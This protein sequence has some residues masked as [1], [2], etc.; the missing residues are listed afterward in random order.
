MKYRVNREEAIKTDS[1]VSSMRDNFY[2]VIDW[3]IFLSVYIVAFVSV[4]AIIH[5]FFPSIDINSTFPLA[6]LGVILG[7][8][9]IGAFGG[10]AA[11][12]FPETQAQM[13][14]QQ[15]YNQIAPRVVNNTTPAP[16]TG[17]TGVV[18]NDKTGKQEEV[19]AVSE[20]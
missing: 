9:F 4:A 2:R 15:Q 14:Q 7:P 19:V 6:P 16:A 12:S 20:E 17:T 1:N 5:G 10:K 3:A 13:Y 11:Q 18:V 8:M